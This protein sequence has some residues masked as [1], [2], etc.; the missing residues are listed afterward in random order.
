MILS[1]DFIMPNEVNMDGFSMNAVSPKL[2]VLQRN[3]I[4]ANDRAPVVDQH[5]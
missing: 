2:S 1:D 3:D 4:M 5:G